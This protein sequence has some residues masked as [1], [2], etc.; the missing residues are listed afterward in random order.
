M[1]YFNVFLSRHS[2]H[3]KNLYDIDNVEKTIYT[4]IYQSISLFH[5]SYNSFTPLRSISVGSYTYLKTFNIFV[6]DWSRTTALWIT[7]QMFS[8]LDCSCIQWRIQ[9]TQYGP[10]SDLVLRSLYIC[11][12]VKFWYKR[13][14]IS[15]TYFKQTYDSF[16]MKGFNMSLIEHDYKL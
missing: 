4:F 15:W 13:T 3:I 6:H 5:T 9:S 12:H 1:G 14:D 7:S 8:S 11:F 16:V 2:L 10:C